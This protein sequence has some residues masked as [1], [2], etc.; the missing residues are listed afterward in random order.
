M[1]IFVFTFKKKWVFL[2]WDTVRCFSFCSL[3]F[4]RVR[5]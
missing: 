2:Q 1:D 5:R 3:C 4:V